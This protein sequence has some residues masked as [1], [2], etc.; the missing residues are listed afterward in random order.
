ME[1][2]RN[3]LDCPLAGINPRAQTQ[4]MID[5]S[6]R[7]WVPG[8]GLHGNS[9]TQCPST[10][11]SEVD[12][13][14]VSILRK[15]GAQTLP[16][17]YSSSK[18]A[19]S[20]DSVSL[21][22]SSGFDPASLV[23]AKEGT[24]AV[25]TPIK[26]YLERH[27]QRC[28]TKEEREALL[29][30]HPRP[31]LEVTKAPP[32]DKYILDFLGSKFPKDQDA[33]LAKIQK[34][35]LACICPLTSAWQELLEDEGEST[36]PA[37][38]VIVLIQRT[39]CLIGNASSF[40]SQIRRAK[41]L[42]TI[43]KSWSKFD[44]GELK[45]PGSLFGDEFRKNLTAKVENEVALAKA[46]SITRRSKGKEPVSRPSRPVGWSRGRFFRRGPPSRYGGRPGQNP[47]PYNQQPYR[48]REVRDHPRGRPPFL[49]RFHEPKL[50]TMG[51]STQ[52]PTKKF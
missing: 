24:I 33:D 52:Q 37:S 31:D 44:T 27:L 3:G 6:P 17:D 19:K 13:T 48:H 36:V 32:A 29:K 10:T 2:H 50:P 4:I 9:L 42:G 16:S 8:W 1:V 49:P 22:T 23:K 15:R 25:P 41:I 5:P 28:L 40:I 39:L 7:S 21:P 35:V 51:T 14:E 26:T 45:S 34:A 12:N 11:D 47:N 18:C 38:D 43:D 30:E 20:E 46:V